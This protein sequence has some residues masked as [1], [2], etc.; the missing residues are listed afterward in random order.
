MNFQHIA[1]SIFSL[2]I[3]ED[4]NIYT[5]TCFADIQLSV[6]YKTHFIRNKKECI[7]SKLKPKLDTKYL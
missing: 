3:I 2:L 6:K 5:S 7:N 4:Y 1:N